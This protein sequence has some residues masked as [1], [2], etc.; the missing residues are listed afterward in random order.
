[1]TER[2]IE[3]KIPRGAGIPEG[4]LISIR[5]GTTRRQAIYGSDR[6]YRFQVPC[7]KS[8]LMK[9]DVY[10]P[11]AS[12]TLFV[13]TLQSQASWKQELKVA[14]ALEGD[15]KALTSTALDNLNSLLAGEMSIDLDMDSSQVNGDEIIPN[16][17]IGRDLKEVAEQYKAA[18]RPVSSCAMT[19]ESSAKRHQ[20]AIE[21]QPYF[22][23]HEVMDVLR[24]LLQVLIKE[25][26]EDPYDF[27][28]QVMENSR[29]QRSGNAA[30]CQPQT[31]A[32]ASGKLRPQTAGRTRAP[33]PDSKQGEHDEASLQKTQPK[34]SVQAASEGQA[35]A[36][37]ERKQPKDVTA[38]SANVRSEIA[39]PPP[40][41]DP[42][43]PSEQL[44]PML[45]SLPGKKEFKLSHEEELE[46]IQ[47][48]VRGCLS[49]KVKEG[50]LE[51]I[52]ADC[53]FGP[54]E[55][56]VEKLPP[57]RGSPARSGTVVTVE[58]VARDDKTV[59]QATH[60]IAMECTFGLEATLFPKSKSA[61]Q[62]ILDI[63]DRLRQKVV[64]KH[65]AGQLEPILLR[66][67]ND[68]SEDAKSAELPHP[69]EETR[70]KLRQAFVE[71]FM[72]GE[73]NEVFEAVAGTGQSLR[74]P[75]PRPPLPCQSAKPSQTVKPSQLA[76]QV[77]PAL[78]PQAPSETALSAVEGSGELE[79]F[80][81]RL[82]VAL[83]SAIEQKTLSDLLQKAYTASEGSPAT[84]SA[85]PALASKAASPLVV[86]ARYVGPAAG[87]GAAAGSKAI[88][89]GAVVSTGA[90][91]PASSSTA[92]RP[93][94][95]QVAVGNA[96]EAASAPGQP[97]RETAR[98]GSW[99][100]EVGQLKDETRSLEERTANLENMV[101]N[102]VSE[103]RNLRQA[104][105]STTK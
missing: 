61:D 22:E 57:P 30:R 46:A 27:M 75:S 8:E 7:S 5:V 66:L 65:D 81:E 56:V 68:D 34:P 36:T 102:L 79:V 9:V 42:S 63:R 95:G 93:V 48:K 45:P 26:P 6:P 18:D 59:A 82:R 98:Q 49:A 60:D 101:R 14:S 47:R 83:T 53:G 52:L 15:Q 67:V 100:T 90:L 97:R 21:A 37:P 99:S 78:R 43:P 10:M 73:L 74:L 29:K 104:I 64:E 89:V 69:S 11:I 2:G 44:L 3:L 33:G 55:S 17:K 91:M 92:A 85:M 39:Q 84:G 77:E 54:A 71:K 88:P 20:V 13:D 4:S 32:P 103:N 76:S 12:A 70:L 1:M 72:A 50:S 41:V 31:I 35:L 96:E 80:R 105:D 62:E 19:R 86:A 24:E 23:Q 40:P 87:P 28:I 58:D 16:E 94:G 38:P 51:A 25:K